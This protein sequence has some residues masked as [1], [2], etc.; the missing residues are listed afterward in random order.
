MP[1][2]KWDNE[3]GPRKFS[4]YRWHIYDAI[5]F[6]KDLKVTVQ[7]LG[8]YPPGIRPGKYRPIPMDFISVAYWYQTEPH[9]KFPEMLPVDKRADF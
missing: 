1:L 6:S 8:W 4:M 9:Q 5:G 3:H 7:S 2:A